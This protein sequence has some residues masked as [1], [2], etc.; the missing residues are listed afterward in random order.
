MPHWTT[1]FGGYSK[2]AGRA[3]AFPPL[4]LAMLA[5]LAEARG[6]S[7]IIIDAEIERL[8]LERTIERLKAFGPDFVG[9]TATTP[10]FAMTSAW[11]SR[12]RAELDAAVVGIGGFHVTLFGEEAFHDHF[13]V[14]FLGEADRSFER[15]L[16][17]FGE[18][19]EYARIPGLMFRK[20]GRVVSTGVAEP[21]PDLD[22]L[23]LPARHLLKTDLYRV[24]SL[25][26]T[27]PYTSIMASRGCPFDCVFCTNQVSGTR[28]RR[29][30]VANVVSEIASVV[31]RHGVRH[32]YF[33][34]DVLTLHR[35]YLLELCAAIAHEAPGI[36]FEGSTRANLVDDEL[37]GAMRRAGL[38]RISFGLESADEAIRDLIRK[39][40]P[41]ESYAEACRTATRH[42]VETIT[43]AM[44]GLPGDTRE[45]IDR[46]IRY[47]R[48]TRELK[49][50]TLSIAMPYPGTELHRMAV[51]GEHGLELLSNDYSRYQ[52]YGSAVM[53]VN[54]IGPEALLRLQRIGLLKIY[55]V[56]WRL[57]P[58]IKRMGILSLLPPVGSALV[59]CAQE[60]ATRFGE[61]IARLVQKRNH[62]GAGTG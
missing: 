59:S 47:L 46:T 29:R 22:L 18:L 50:S 27:L 17:H 49:H 35:G 13:D 1:V 51:R 31:E 23:P 52:R 14:A 43:S 12:V 7:V 19:D 45:S 2:V 21:S 26:G 25:K 41:L 54:G 28:V 6:H 61:R 44:L 39:D 38:I 10:I 62:S 34:D 24:G 30:S 15:F 8:S 55:L 48:N 40:V 37:M 58:V 16:D 20:E 60:A 3:S 53:S 57:I 4:N 42:G 11:A 5:A 56:P 33:V 32:F 9:F 36:T